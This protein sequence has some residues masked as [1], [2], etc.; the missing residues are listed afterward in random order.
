LSHRLSKPTKEELPTK[1]AKIL[2]QIQAILEGTESRTTKAQ[3]VAELIRT[4]Q[5]YRWVGLYD[6]KVDEIRIIGWSGP[7]EPTHTR[8]PIQQGLCG[9]AVHS[10][11]PIVV[12]D[13]SKDP[14]YLTTFGSTRSEMIVPVLA[15][16]GEPVGLIDVES[17]RLCAF[18]KEDQAFVE[19]CAS[20]IAESFYR[21]TP[22]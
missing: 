18:A 8:F 10:R 1:E 14:R 9:A 16:S 21:R 19:R 2:A 6:V 13:V 22:S 5:G 4:A 3:R 7:G 11:A 15:P 12:D 20:R 17:D